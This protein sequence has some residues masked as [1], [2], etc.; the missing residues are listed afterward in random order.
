MHVSVVEASPEQ[1]VLSAPLAPNINHQSTVFGGSAASLA[2][3][4]AWSLLHIKLQAEGLPSTVVVQRSGMSYD[5]AI[6][7]DFT[8]RA[9]APPHEIWHPFKAMLQRKGRARINTV[10]FLFQNE[11]V[12]G[13]LE[14]D[15]VALRAAV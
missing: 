4:A 8:A 10:A 15:F 5:K 1:V 6:D 3:L 7:G 9:S 2:T 12:A 14:G 11:Q 13:R